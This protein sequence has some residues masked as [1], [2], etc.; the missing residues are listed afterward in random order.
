M[1][2]QQKEQ[3]RLFS[4]LALVFISA[5]L[6][7]NL[8]NSANVQ[9]GVKSELAEISMAKYELLN[10]EVW[11]NKM[12]N[13]I[14]KRVDEFEVSSENKEELK[15]S[16]AS[17]LDDIIQYLD[18]KNRQKV[19]DCDGWFDCT[20]QVIRQGTT[21]LIFDIQEIR[22][23]VPA[24]TEMAFKYFNQPGVKEEIKDLIKHKLNEVPTTLAKVDKTKYNQILSWNDCD[25]A[26]ACKPYLQNKIQR[27]DSEIQSNFYWLIALSIVIF[28]TVLVSN[29]QFTQIHFW[30][31]LGSCLL[32]LMAGI[33]MPM[34]EIEAK[35][36]ELSFTLLGGDVSF[37][38]QVL[39]YQNKSVTDIVGL[40]M[41]S[42]EFKMV[43]V[44]AL[45]SLFSVLF[46]VTKLASS[47]IYYHDFK[48]LRQ[49]KLIAF[50]TLK[51]G[52]WSMADVMVVAIFMAYVG[53]DGIVDAQLSQVGSMGRS[54]DVLTTS[55]GTQLQPGFYLFLAF[56]LASLVLSSVLDKRIVGRR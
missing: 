10:A 8:I 30:T 38:N 53:F 12:Y 6:T 52:K 56:C 49:H 16:I 48:G 45:V 51:S 22:Q 32:L 26:L 3:L 50:F 42:G 37:T 29:T 5:I 21:D 43:L 7:F 44:G 25:S 27:L 4:S 23:S 20:S 33:N 46:P 17:F 14:A 11:A 24:F 18:N 9:R 36:A 40:L 41:G 35:I 13:I 39:F 15:A 47:I 34:I 28:A 55:G 31:L 54:L 1:Q 19:R 2:L